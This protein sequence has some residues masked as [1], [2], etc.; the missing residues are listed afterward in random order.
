MAKRKRAPSLKQRD[1]AT[2]AQAKMLK[3]M[4]VLSKKTKLH[5]GKFV[6]RGVVKRVHDLGWIV[7]NNQKAV[8]VP[9]AL[10]EKAKEQGLHTVG[11]RIV[12]PRDGRSTRRLEQGILTGVKYVPGGQMQVVH[13]PYSSMSEFLAALQ[14]GEIDRLK[15]SK[16]HFAFKYFGNTSNA[17]RN[18]QHLY[19]WLI[20]YDSITNPSTGETLSNLNKQYSN[21]V[22]YKLIPGAG[23]PPIYLEQRNARHDA[24][25]GRQAAHDSRASNHRRQKHMQRS[26]LFQQQRKDADAARKRVSRAALKENDPVAYERMLSRNKA[27]AIKSKNRRKGQPK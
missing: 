21:F 4:G 23:N 8:K 1:K 9:R 7:Q 22:L 24:R 19:E 6:S 14:S 25:A 27:R 26:E 5:G 20:K 16:E 17:F 15:D 2:I 3:A 18:S 12:V 10:L 11:N 13:L